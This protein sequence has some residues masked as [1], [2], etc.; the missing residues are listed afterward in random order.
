L[1]A[2]VSRCIAFICV[3]FTVTASST[4]A[5]RGYMKKSESINSI[6]LI[7][8]IFPTSVSYLTAPSYLDFTS[9]FYKRF[10]VTSKFWE[11]S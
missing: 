9:E 7:I 3:D 10:E 8:N 4:A 2:R 6:F 5:L 11:F 1:K